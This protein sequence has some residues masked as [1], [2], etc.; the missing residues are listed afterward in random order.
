MSLLKYFPFRRSK[1]INE[2]FNNAVRVYALRGE[3]DAGY[4]AI[5]AAR[6]SGEKHKHPMIEEL[7]KMASNVMKNYPDKIARKSIAD[8]IIFLKREIEN[9]RWDSNDLKEGKERLSKANAE[10]LSCLNRI[11]PSV[12]KQKHPNLF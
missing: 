9:L 6:A 11:D 3:E 12:F 4:A 5:A 10:Y 8:R 2:Y 1:K 7:S